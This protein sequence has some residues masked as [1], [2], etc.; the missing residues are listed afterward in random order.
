MNRRDFLKGTG[1][2]LSA[3]AAMGISQAESDAESQQ[4]TT[5]TTTGS[6]N[7]TA[8]QTT[9]KP[10]GEETVT[11]E[12]GPNGSNKFVPEQVYITPG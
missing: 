11:V 2:S 9:T 4:T 10:T 1:G 5:Q 8:T 6:G 12:V 7:Q 3:L